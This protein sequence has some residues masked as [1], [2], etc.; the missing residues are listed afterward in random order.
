M[1]KWLIIGMWS[2][3]SFAFGQGALGEVVGE[4]IYGNKKEPAYGARVWIEDQGK[5]YQAL[6]NP[7]GRFRISAI[8]AGKY[9]LMILF[10]A[11]TMSKI[12]VNVPLEGYDNLGLIKFNGKVQIIDEMD[13]TY[14]KDDIRL[15]YGELPV[16]SLNAKDIVRMP[17]KFDMSSMV[18]A[19][20]SDVKRSDDGELMFRGSRKGDMV[21]VL[22]GIKSPNMYNIPSAAISNMMVYTGGIPAKYGDTLGGVVVVESKS[23]FEL[24]RDWER[25][26]R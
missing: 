17:A 7:D 14:H 2:F 10:Q 23:Y 24:L 25:T 12:E 5:K 26:Q 1:K 16:R 9:E 4:V 15:V 18:A 3:G 11:D 13:A 19:I 22:D 8:P 20:S 21:Y 6:C